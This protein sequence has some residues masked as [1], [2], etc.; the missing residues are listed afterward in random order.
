MRGSPHNGC[1]LSSLVN[2]P[3]FALGRRQ[4]ATEQSAQIPHLERQIANL[5]RVIGRMQPRPSLASQLKE[6][7][8]Q[9]LTV[10]GT[11]K[12]SRKTHAE[13]ERNLI[14]AQKN[15]HDTE[16]A[17][18]A[19]KFDRA[20]FE[21]LDATRE[22]ASH[23]GNLRRVATTTATDVREA[24]GRLKT[25]EM[26]HDRANAKAEAADQTWKR[27]SQ[28]T[29]EVDR[30]LADARHQDA[31]ALLRRELRTGEP[32]QVCERPVLEHPPPLPTPA[33]DALERK[34]ERA[35][36]A[37]TKTRE[38]L[39]QARGAAAAAEEAVVGEQQSVAQSSERS[40]AAEAELANACNALAKRVRGVI[41]VSEEPTIEEQVRESYRVV[42]ATRQLHEA[43]RTKRDEADELLRNAEQSAQ[44]LTTVVETATH[45]LE[46]HN[47]R[48]VD[49]ARQI[50][51]IDEE[52]SKVTEAPDPGV[53]RAELGRRRD[54]LAEVLEA[55]KAAEATASRELAGVAGRLE[56]SGEIH[57]KANDE[58]QRARVE[59][60]GAAD[61]AG[62][63]DE[64]A[65]A[66][67]EITQAEDRRISALVDEHRHETRTVR[68][69]IEE[70]TD[71]LKG[72]E[73]T[74]ETLTA[75]E[76]AVAQLRTE[77][78]TVERSSAE[79][80]ARIENLR[81]D[82]GRAKELR[83]DLARQQADHSLFSS[84]ALDLRSDRFQ[85]FLL[86]ETFRE[87]VTGASVRLWELTNRYR[88]DWQNEAFYVIDHDNAR[89]LRSAD[90]LSGGE[91]FLAS[92]ALALQLSVQVQKAAGATRLDSLFI[93]EGFGTLDPE[94]LAAAADAI[95]GLPV[96]GRMVGVISH[97]DEL[98]LRLPAR[99]RVKKGSEGSQITVEAT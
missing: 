69:R 60:R 85:A 87:L 52:V 78:S 62:F 6:A 77:V 84:L 16:E 53:E 59:A 42:S 43:A 30:E 45:Q 64:A 81:K 1:S 95:E 21:T 33:I 23:I 67:A 40:D 41:A 66:E 7:K 17:L 65:A 31:A 75:A 8:K 76:T 25:K 15:L 11:L 10:D 56:A 29:L 28:R 35:R 97:L 48:I 68:V 55:R 27:A 5:D 83:D 9:Q 94:A 34:L 26:A 14:T 37:E 12:E 19:V 38:L 57:I 89:Q 79:L 46:Q 44:R 13:A 4:T 36:G 96:G 72:T 50:A 86:E 82:I 90:T 3:G 99:V 39:D 74:E 70:L 61:A 54:N 63:A 93:D 32:C 2:G 92:L 88:F 18:A 24:E 22:E 20:L 47:S 71:E 80:N 73:A 98:T 51:E 49:L 91:T 58:A